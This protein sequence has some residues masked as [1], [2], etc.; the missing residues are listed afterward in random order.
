MKIKTQQWQFKDQTNNILSSLY[1]NLL[2]SNKTSGQYLLSLRNPCMMI[3]ILF[4][5]MCSF[6][7]CIWRI[8]EP[9]QW[10]IFEIV[11]YWPF[12]IIKGLSVYIGLIKAIFAK[13]TWIRSKRLV[14]FLCLLVGLEQVYRHS[15]LCLICKFY[16]TPFVL[17]I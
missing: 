10:N 12:V 17:I 13:K 4:S 2:H 15:T 3:G 7:R 16:G 5:D 6:G 11:S 8:L 9:F 14:T 1:V